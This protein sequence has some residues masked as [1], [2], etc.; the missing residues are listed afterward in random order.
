[1]S[2]KDETTQRVRV[3]MLRPRV[4]EQQDGYEI[5]YTAPI[6]HETRRVRR[7]S[8]DEITRPVKIESVTEM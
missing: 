7:L 8:D 4:I 3:P 2:A 6:E 1:M 5:F